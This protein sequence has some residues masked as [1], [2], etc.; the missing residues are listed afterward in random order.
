MLTDMQVRRL[1]PAGK[2]YKASDSG[3]L[4]LQVSPT[5]S[6]LWRMKYRFGGKEK[7]L[8]FGSYPAVS[9]SDARRARDDARQELREGRDPSLTRKQRR[10][11]AASSETR[12]QAVGEAWLAA[13][14]PTWTDRHYNDVETS[15]SRLVWPKIGSIPI[16]EITPPMVL[17][18]IR[19][20][21]K[22]R[23]LET[24]RRVRQRLSAIF[25]YGIATGVGFADPADV[26]KGALAPLK[27][28]HQPAITDLEEL[29]QMIADVESI[30]A[31][32][33]TILA[34][35]FLALTAVRPGEVRAMP[36][37]EVNG[38]VWEIPAE[39]MK[40]KRPHVVPL[41]RQAMETLAAVR[42]LTGRGPLV[43]PNARWAHR[44]MSE[45]AI[46]YMINRAGYSGRHVP[47][48][49]RAAF[50]SIM[51]E[52]LPHHRM[53]IDQMLAHALKDKV[54]GAYNRAQHLDLRRLIYQI[55]ADILL[56]KDT[57]MEE[58]LI[59]N[60]R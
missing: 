12:L 5:G 19:D 37:A 55:W 59:R 32:P 43:F 58:I 14:K 4:Y 60:R 50:S 13:Q 27:K 34:M 47:H 39:R 7:L 2:S 23:A 57:K 16:P 35:R 44:P 29:R 22:K 48:G 28:G 30:P 10:A 53:I 21:E 26:I 56:D 24:A 54:E 9:L 31:H 17:S 18:V 3:G 45:N 49:F 46:G 51:N 36:W 8:S 25:C 20:I 1:L 33:V 38:D 41:S 40:M 52:K 15:L 11:Q 6:K 42:N